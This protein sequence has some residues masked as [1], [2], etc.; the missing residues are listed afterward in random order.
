MKFKEVKNLS[1]AE[2]KDLLNKTRNELRELR[3]KTS[4]GQLKTVR[5]I[6]AKRQLVARTLTLLNTKK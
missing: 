4:S 6:R 2:L 5:E 1:E 3:F